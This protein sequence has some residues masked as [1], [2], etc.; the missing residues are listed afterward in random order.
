[1]SSTKVIELRDSLKP[2]GKAETIVNYW[3]KWNDQRQ[4]IRQQ[5]M[6]LQKYIFATDTT[7]TTNQTLPWKNT[8]TIPKLCQLRDNL[9]SNYLSAL[10][11]NDRWL[12]WVA[13]SKESA[14]KEKANTIK[15][16]MSNKTREGGYRET[17]SRCLLDYIDYGNAFVISTFESRY[18]TTEERG[19]VPSFIGPRAE[20]LSPLDIV[21]NPT[22]ISFEK[23]PKIVRSVKT[24]GE[25]IRYSETHPNQAFWGDVV[26]RRMDVLKKY[27]GWKAEDWDKASQYQVDGFGSLFEYYCSDYVEILEFYG[28]IYD[29]DTN[30]VKA[31]QMI[32]VADRCMVAREVDIPT[33]SGNA[34]IRHVGWRKR[35][36]N[37]W[38]MGP[39]DNLVG[40]QYKIDH[41]ENSKADALDL[42]VN[43]P[44]VIKGEVEQFVYAPNAEIHTDEN[45]D[46]LE[47]GRGM[48]GVLA[49]D[50]AIEGYEAR[51]EMYAGAPREA[52]GIRTP[53]EKTAFEMETLMTAAGR[54]FQ[55]KITAFETELM[56]PNLNDMLEQAYLNFSEIDVIRTID[57]DLGA[58]QFREITVDDITAK[59]ILRPVGARHFA[60]QAKDLQNL[61]AVANSPLG[62]MIAPHT[63]SKALT[64]FISDNLGITAYEIFKPNIAIAEQM[65]TERLVGQAQEDLAAEAATPTEDEMMLDPSQME[66][67]QEGQGFENIAFG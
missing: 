45:G 48:N 42:L 49:A 55:E 11:P 30:T 23:S 14:S 40:M 13:Y 57:N 6:E 33:L 2:L 24:L 67:P 27:G 26:Q 35:P 65:E 44:L 61:M 8:T 60:Q 16:Y 39:F 15:A 53:G 64:E 19:H 47:L 4:G 7:T 10:F 31:N 32:T 1:M 17:M 41:Y 52:M 36:D 9:H 59:G 22:A 25:L 46:V 21:F 20:R 63:S 56:E 18:N 38:C 37:L 62:Q 50:S 28:D 54:I 3:T 43:P 12:S 51:M 5:W 58:V 34:P 29:C 66:E